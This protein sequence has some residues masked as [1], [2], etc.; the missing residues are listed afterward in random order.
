MGITAEHLIKCYGRRTVVDD[1]SF[2]LES[3]CV[4]GFIGPNGAGKTTTMRML[5][6]YMPPTDGTIRVAGFDVFEEP[7]EVKR[8]IGYL[9][10]LPPVYLDMTVRGYLEFC[11][12]LKG[13]R[14]KAVKS[15]VDRAE[16]ATRTAD[17]EERLIGNL[18]KGYRQRVGLAQAILGSPPVLIL[19]EPTVGLDPVQIIEVREL[20][21][22]LAKSGEHTISLSTHILHEVTELC[23]K[24]LVIKGGRMVGFDTLEGFRRRLVDG[25]QASLEEIYLR[26]IEAPGIDP[27]SGEKT[28]AEASPQVPPETSSKGANKGAEKN[29]GG[30][31]PSEPSASP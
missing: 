25:R 16:E 14:R 11:A 12:R 17:V 31:S 22:S 23:Q 19:D 13:L 7:L 3:G 8:R 4:L 30:D 24:V 21:Q 28:A 9:P 29:A 6:G 26:L 2:T 5:T 1:L 18:S 10:E 15:E 20:V 27:L